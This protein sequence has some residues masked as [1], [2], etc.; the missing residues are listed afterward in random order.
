M[1]TRVEN[2]K[3]DFRY[4]LFVDDEL[5]GI[6][7]Y[8]PSGDALVFPHT[9]IRRDLRGRG[10]GEVLVRGALEDARASGK[11]IV[12]RCW[13]VE[14]FVELNPEFADLLVA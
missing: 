1:M 11:R 4:E 9:Q 13:Y 7:D 12:P 3:Q 10:Y 6:A 5:A 8:L 14:R 2:N